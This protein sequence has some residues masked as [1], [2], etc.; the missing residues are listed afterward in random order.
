[1][2]FAWAFIIPL[3]RADN[4]PSFSLILGLGRVSAGGHTEVA[5]VCGGGQAVPTFP[6]VVLMG[7]GGV[8]ATLP[9]RAGALLPSP[10]GGGAEATWGL[11]ASFLLVPASPSSASP[12]AKVA[13]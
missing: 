6:V 12:I 11:L 5:G 3:M 7:G 1:M 4:S 10:E 9:L 8:A 13:T 2:S